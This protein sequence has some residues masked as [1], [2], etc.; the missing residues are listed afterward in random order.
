MSRAATFKRA[1]LTRATQA[2]MAAALHVARVEIGK[3]GTITV[4]P[5]KPT[6]P[7]QNNQSEWDEVLATDGTAAEIR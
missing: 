4:V 3:N 5:G 6:E 1:D 2:V 7:I